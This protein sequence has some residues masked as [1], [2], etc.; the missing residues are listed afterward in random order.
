MDLLVKKERDVYK[1]T[2]ATLRR[3]LKSK[4]GRVNKAVEIVLAAPDL[5]HLIARLTADKRVPSYKKSSLK[6]ALA[7]YFAPIDLLPEAAL[8]PIG[9]IEDVLLGAVVLYEF[10]NDVDQSLIRKYWAGDWDILVFLQS[11]VDKARSIV[12]PF[13]WKRIQKVIGAGRNGGTPVAGKVDGRQEVM[14]R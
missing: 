5:F 2:R 14:V 4:N 1:K 6:F 7:Y 8:G 3:W 9:L 10:L 13:V 11:L 12:G